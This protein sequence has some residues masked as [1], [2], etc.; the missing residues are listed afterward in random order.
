M[1]LKERI[2]QL[3]KENKISMNRLEE[4]LGFG[5]GYISK[6]GVSTPNVSKI[7]LIADYFNVTIDYVLGN[8]QNSSDLNID[9][10]NDKE[11]INNYIKLDSRGKHKVHTVIYEE[12]DRIKKG[13]KETDTG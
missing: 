3:C 2:K 6:L 4:V 1:N 7:Q 9:D 8:E 10:I 12:L 11:M 13:E 5:K